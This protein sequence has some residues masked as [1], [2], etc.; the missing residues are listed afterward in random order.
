MYDVSELIIM[1][2][3]VSFFG[4][5]LENIFIA[6]RHGHMDNRGMH[7]PF[8]LG[9]GLAVLA[10]YIVLGT[11]DAPRFPAVTHTG[12]VSG[13]FLISA[14]AVSVGELILGFTVE[15]KFGFSY[16]DYSSIP[17]HITKYTSV[18]TSMGFGAVITLFMHHCFEPLMTLISKFPAALL[19]PAAGILMCMLIWDFVTS[20]LY[21]HKN[22][23]LKTIWTIALKAP[24][25]GRKNALAADRR[26]AR[27]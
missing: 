10:F 17:M 24:G 12:G 23:C 6:F 22:H 5:W 26:S 8:L 13:Y 9:Y 15:K 18:P 1:T 19:K 2:A 16:W 11:P 7:L 25:A 14:A 20:F 21:M 4:F 27:R 3:A